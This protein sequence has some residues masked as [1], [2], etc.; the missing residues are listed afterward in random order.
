[1]PYPFLR[2]QPL[3]VQKSFCPVNRKAMDREKL[4]IRFFLLFKETE[5]DSMIGANM[6][7][8]NIYFWDFCLFFFMRYILEEGH[9]LKHRIKLVTD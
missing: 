2:G 8:K 4:L 7:E 5:G 3:K 6:K 1:M 9:R